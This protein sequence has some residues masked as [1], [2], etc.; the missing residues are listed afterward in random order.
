MFQLLDSSF[1]VWEVALGVFF[2]VQH[3][4]VWFF[5]GCDGLLMRT[6]KDEHASSKGSVCKT[7]VTRRKPEIGR[8]GPH[9]VMME[10]FTIV[11]FQP[12]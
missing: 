5:G 12:F 10:I 6:R 8:D 3:R 4:V 9:D 2:F 1:V 7:R 11:F